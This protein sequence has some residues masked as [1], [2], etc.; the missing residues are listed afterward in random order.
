[1]KRIAVGDVKA[2]RGKIVRGRFPLLELPTGVNDFLAVVILQG[3]KPGPCL[4]LTA[5]IHGDENT[6]LVALF[7]GIV[8]TSLF[9][10]A[11]QR[12]SQASELA[13]VDATQSSEVVFALVGEMLILKAPLPNGIAVSGM[14]L[15]FVGLALFIR[16]QEGAG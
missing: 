11:R 7:S 9:L 6:G 3:K 5:N 16:F 1:M 13:M 14:V 10:Y 2:V 12:S 15:V 4:W 8:A